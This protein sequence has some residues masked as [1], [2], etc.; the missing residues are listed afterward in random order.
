MVLDALVEDDAAERKE[1]LTPSEMVLRVLE[2][3]TGVV[4]LIRLANAPKLLLTI[5][6]AK[7]DEQLARVV[8]RDQ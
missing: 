2:V 5:D 4:D 6:L 7:E 1:M 3:V 8:W